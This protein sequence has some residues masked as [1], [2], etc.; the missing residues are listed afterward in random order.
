MWHHADTVK[1]TVQIYKKW[2]TERSMMA[3]RAQCKAR[4]AKEQIEKTQQNIA[5]KNVEN[6]KIKNIQ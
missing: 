3:E 4:E 5:D 6:K 2:A 1:K